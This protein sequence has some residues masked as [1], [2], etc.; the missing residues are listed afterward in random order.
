MKK[1]QLVYK[2][3]PQ[4]KIKNSIIVTSWVSEVSEIT[5]EQYDAMCKQIENLKIKQTES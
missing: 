1:R 4:K 5:E 3:Q 2:P